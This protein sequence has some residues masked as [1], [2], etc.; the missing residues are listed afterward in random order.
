MTH[1]LLNGSERIYRWLL[2]AYP[3]AFR[4]EYGADM[5]QVFRDCCR[6]A[7]EQGGNVAVVQLWLLT[8]WDLVITVLSQHLARRTQ[9]MENTHTTDLFDRQLGSTVLSMTVLLRGGYSVLQSFSMIAHDSPEP[10]RSAFAQFVSD[11]EAG[12]PSGEAL[13]ELKARV[14]STHLAQV[15][16]TMLK[17]RETGGNLADQLEPVAAVIRQQAGDDD[18]TNALLRR[19]EELTQAGN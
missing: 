8:G 5:A 13:T 9:R 7:V 19:F 2:Y 4:E 15:I 17:Q 12:K 16:D 6:E 1:T 3:A 10:L 18:A 11:V 14:P